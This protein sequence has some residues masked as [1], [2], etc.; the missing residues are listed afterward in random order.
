MR[1]T[2]AAIATLAVAGAA[3]A[4]TDPQRDVQF[5]SLD[6]GTNVLEVHNFGATAM[7]LDGWR[8]CSHSSGQAR[9]YTAA[10]SL[11]GVSLDPAESMF[12]HMNNDAPAGDLNFNASDL[13]NFANNFGQGPFAI[14]F[15]WPNGGTLSFASTDDMVDHV[16]WSV[17][18]VNNPIAATRS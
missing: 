7:P 16:Q 15:F 12:I 17:G 2:A 6:L 8:F 9:R 4:G 14:Q 18:G 11:N 5:K 13:G 3:V 1:L 10:A